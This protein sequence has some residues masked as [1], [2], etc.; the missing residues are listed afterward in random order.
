M[1]SLLLPDSLLVG[2]VLVKVLFSGVCGA[3]VNE[4]DAVKGPDKFLPHLLGH[5]GY[6]EVVNV[7]PGVRKI[8]AGDRVVL[9]WMPGIGI[10]GVPAKYSVANEVINSGWVTTFSEMAIVSENRCTPVVSSLPEHMLPLFGCAATTAAG[11]IGNEARLRLGESV[12]VLGAGGVGLAT[13]IA[14]KASG[15]FPV[16]VVD[17]VPSRLQ[18]AAELGADF[19]LNPKDITNIASVIVESLGGN[20]SVVIETT[21]NREMIELSYQ[22]AQPSGRTVLVGVPNAQEPAV[23]PTLP[24]H[25]GMSFVGSKGGST[26]PDEDIPRLIRAAEAGVF[27]VIDIP[28]T[29]FPLGDIN[30]ALA[31]LRGS[32]PGRMVLD[33]R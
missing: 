13:V 9:H 20:P 33:C 27:R 4:I 15:G 1:E 14:S 25:L 11:V 26:S 24:L 17:I 31:H 16:G 12:V 10:E 6:G 3:Q 18:K 22:L 23:I 7:G 29:I 19:V 21:G 32:E 8:M 2:Q 30:S 5:E 28:A